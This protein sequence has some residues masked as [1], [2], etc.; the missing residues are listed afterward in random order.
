MIIHD[1]QYAFFD[2][3]AF[4]SIHASL[5]TVDWLTNLGLEISIMAY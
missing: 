2:A 5:I 4:V 1:I 3:T